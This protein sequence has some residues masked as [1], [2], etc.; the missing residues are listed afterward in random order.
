MAAVISA[1]HTVITYLPKYIRPLV[2]GNLISI[3]NILT[4]LA[5]ELTTAGH[6]QRLP[7]QLLL[8]L[9][10]MIF[11]GGTSDSCWHHECISNFGTT[12]PYLIAHTLVLSMGISCVSRI[13][14]SLKP[15]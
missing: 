13:K 3:Y 7:S 10:V 4:T 5:Y 1:A 2:W 8:S 14:R 9:K 11:I 6:T 12:Y 15:S